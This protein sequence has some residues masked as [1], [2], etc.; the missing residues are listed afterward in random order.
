MTATL[1]ESLQAL[2]TDTNLTEVGLRK[3]LSALIA[4]HQSPEQAAR[5]MR[6]ARFCKVCGALQNAAEKGSRDG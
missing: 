5:G 3:Q 1:L 6:F 4:Q 2:V